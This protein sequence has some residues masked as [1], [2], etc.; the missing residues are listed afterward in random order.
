MTLTPGCCLQRPTPHQPP[1]PAALHHPKQQKQNSEGLSGPDAC[2]AIV[3]MVTL[4]LTSSTFSPQEGQTQERNLGHLWPW[5][6][7]VLVR[8]RGC[9][10]DPAWSSQEAAGNPPPQPV[11]SKFVI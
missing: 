1:T 4:F 7:G 9:C 3:W 11:G 5:P 10:G 6:Q 2:R 8:R